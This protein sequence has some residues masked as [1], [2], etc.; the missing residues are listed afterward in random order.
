MV[1]WY[2]LKPSPWV[3]KQKNKKQGED[4]RPSAK[5]KRS[6]QQRKKRVQQGISD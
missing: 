6:K 2:Q 5:R 4:I 3:K 1:V